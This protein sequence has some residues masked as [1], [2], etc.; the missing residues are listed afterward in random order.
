MF[1]N[2]IQV[3]QEQKVAYQA[4]VKRIEEAYAESN[5][6]IV[7]NVDRLGRFHAPCDGYFITGCGEFR[8]NYDDVLF[9]KGEFLPVPLDFEDE[10]FGV[11]STSPNNYKAERRVKST[12]SK[13]DEANEYCTQ[14]E[15]QVQVKAGK[16][17]EQDGIQLAYAYIKARNVGLA[18]A[19]KADLEYVPEVVEEAEVY[20]DEDCRMTVTGEI[21]FI[22]CYEGNYGPQW[23]MLVQTPEG[24][25]LFGSAPSNVADEDI[26]K[27]VTFTA[28]MQRGLNG[29]TYYKRPTKVIVI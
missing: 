18:E 4:R 14:N 3:V 19:M 23:K 21:K 11:L 29:L 12:V 26:G 13:I 27:N 15:I 16:S 7:P 28:A 9:G 22:K 8:G 17:W 24:H 2:L 20:F 25:K 1:K 5:G 10:Y 6:G